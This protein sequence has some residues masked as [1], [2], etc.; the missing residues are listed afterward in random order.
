MN[1][2]GFHALRHIL[3][4]PSDNTATA[5]ADLEKGE[6]L[7]LDRVGGKGLSITLTEPIPFAHKFAIALIRRGDEVRKY[8]EW[9]GQA[10]QDIHPGEHVHVHNVESQRTRGQGR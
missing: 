9:I 1:R 5:L 8:G 2:Q 6:V 4:H 7:R 10:S 3:L